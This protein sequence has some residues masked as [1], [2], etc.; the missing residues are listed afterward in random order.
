[1]KI[2]WIGG[3]AIPPSFVLARAKKHFSKMKHEVLP[4]ITSARAEEDFDWVVG[5][6]LGAFLLLRWPERFPAKRGTVLLAPFLDFPREAELGGRVSRR[7][8]KITVRYLRKDPLAA[9]NDFFERADLGL[10]AAALPYSVEDLAWG[11]EVLQSETVSEADVANL[12]HRIILGE[13]D[14][15]LDA[16][17]ITECLPKATIL[18]ECGHRFEDL[19]AGFHFPKNCE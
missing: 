1:V 16:N 8:L 7:Q 4:P 5:H 10:F 19:L 2:L 17:Q 15:L 9:V 13:R 6:S 11:L 12:N 18:P 14:P 3:W